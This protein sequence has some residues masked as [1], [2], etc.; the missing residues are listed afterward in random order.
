MAK[1]GIELVG[2]DGIVEREGSLEAELGQGEGGD[3][4]LPKLAF[5]AMTAARRI[6]SRAPWR[7]SRSCPARVARASDRRARQSSRCDEASARSARSCSRVATDCIRVA[8]KPCHH[9]AAARVSTVASTTPTT[10]FALRRLRRSE[11]RSAARSP[12]PGS[13]AGGTGALNTSD[14]GN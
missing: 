8:R 6:V 4:L 12:G 7:R 11:S 9:A 13:G 14:T 3:G 5:G 2:P 1:L 10:V